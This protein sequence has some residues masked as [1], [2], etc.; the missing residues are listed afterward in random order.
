ME[1]LW[2]WIRRVLRKDATSTTKIA[3]HWTPEEKHKRRRPTCKTTWGRKVK[4]KVQ[5]YNLSWSSV[6]KT[7]K[8][9][10]NRKAFVPAL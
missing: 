3:V 10:M 6:E 9:R 8:Y 1:R 5:Q 4:E 2:R 7:A